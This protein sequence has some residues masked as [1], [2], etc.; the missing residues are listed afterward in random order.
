MAHSVAQL[1]DRA[2]AP[3]RRAASEHSVASDG[4]N[5]RP[6]MNAAGGG[7]PQTCPE[8]AVDKVGRSN[9]GIVEGAQAGGRPL[10][11]NTQR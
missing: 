5:R 7:E 2:A 6:I 10:R 3:Q 8:R 11:F 4:D 9:R 1:H